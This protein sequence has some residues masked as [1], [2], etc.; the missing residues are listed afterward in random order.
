VVF[1]GRRLGELF[2]VDFIDRPIFFFEEAVFF[3]LDALGLADARFLAFFLVRIEGV[4]SRAGGAPAGGAENCTTA[5]AALVMQNTA[6]TPITPGVPWMLTALPFTR[7]RPARK[8]VAAPNGSGAPQIA[9][10]MP[11]TRD[12]PPATVRI[13]LSTVMPFVMTN[14]LQSITAP[15]EP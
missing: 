6:V 15:K 1:F 8:F 13:P 7:P 3:F 10:G 5:A 9:T 14:R 2:L 11:F 4:G 12:M